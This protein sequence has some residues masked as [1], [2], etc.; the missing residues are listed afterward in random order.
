MSRKFR[1]AVAFAV[2]LLASVTPAKAAQVIELV[3]KVT[4]IRTFTASNNPYSESSPVE[5]H[6]Y[7]Q[8]MP[9][10]CNQP[11]GEARFS[12]RATHPAYQTVISLATTALV[13]GKS[14]RIFYLDTCTVRASSWDFSAMDLLSN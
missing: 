6:V 2:V 7:V 8:G 1:A 10:A 5:A 13:S 4:H 14:L 3:G 11:S 12:I 9:P